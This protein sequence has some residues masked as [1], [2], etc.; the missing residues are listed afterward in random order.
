[1]KMSDAF[2]EESLRC[3]GL[4]F[5]D[6]T[7]PLDDAGFDA[8]LNTKFLKSAHL[9]SDIKT[10]VSK[11]KMATPMSVESLQAYHSSFCMALIPLLDEIQLQNTS[12]DLHVTLIK[13]FYDGI[14]GS[15]AFKLR[16]TSCST[17]MAAQ[18]NFRDCLTKSNV[19]L[20]VAHATKAADIR[21][22][23]KKYDNV[24]GKRALTAKSRIPQVS[25]TPPKREPVPPP[26]KALD[27]GQPYM[28]KLCSNCRGKHPTDVCTTLPCFI[29]L[30]YDEPHTH[31]QADCP[32]RARVK[33]TKAK[34]ARR[35]AREI[36]FLARHDDSED[37]F[38]TDDF[39]DT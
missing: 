13:A 37:S 38:Y 28:G 8:Y 15:F 4:M 34:V 16:E 1:M 39:S 19:Q 6:Q 25:K 33:A 14:P 20:A 23:D 35:R 27:T 11:I 22:Q 36:Q 32:Y 10:A 9:F 5:S 18:N 12:Q 2:G 30:E 17:W 24:E 26:P 31:T 3:L 21:Q 29:C 7:V